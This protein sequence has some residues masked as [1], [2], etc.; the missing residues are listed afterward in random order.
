MIATCAMAVPSVTSH[1]LSS[2]RIVTTEAYAWDCDNEIGGIVV[3]DK[4]GN[5]GWQVNLESTRSDDKMMA[6]G[7]YL[8][9]NIPLEI[10]AENNQARLY[11]GRQ[12]NAVVTTQLQGDVQVE[13]IK[14]IYAM[15]EQYLT[16]MSVLDGDFLAGTISDNGSITF[17]EGFLFLIQEDV[18][19]KRGNEVLEQ[20]TT[21]SLSPVFRNYSLHVPN[22]MHHFKKLYY[23]GQTSF[24][25]FPV[26]EGYG[27]GGIVPRPPIM[28]GGNSENPSY[29]I[30]V[31]ILDSI[32]LQMTAVTIVASKLNKNSSLNGFLTTL[33]AGG[34]V[35][36]PPVMSGGNSENSSYTKT[37]HHDPSDFS[38]FAMKSVTEIRNHGITD[39]INGHGGLVPR[40]PVMSGGNSEN[41]SYTKTHHHDPSDFSVADIKSM[42][43]G[44][45]NII[46]GGGGIIPNR[47]VMSGGNSENPCYTKL[48]QDRDYDVPR[49]NSGIN[50]TGEVSSNSPHNLVSNNQIGSQN[51]TTSS[52]M[53]ECAVE[54]PVYI[55]QL[56]GILKVYNLYGTSCCENFMTIDSNGTMF[57]PGQ[58]IGHD[59]EDNV[60][61]INCSLNADTCDYLN[62]GI[63]G[64][65]T[66]DNITWGS[67]VPC[68][69]DEVYQYLY[70][71]NSLTLVNGCQFN[72]PQGS[73]VKVLGDVSNDCKVDIADVTEM[74]DLMLATGDMSSFDQSKTA[75]DVNE[76]G[77]LNIADVTTLIDT[78]LSNA[79]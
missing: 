11:M 9:N 63:L 2:T 53:V 77:K 67:I 19:Y 57:F 54:V 45:N 6:N 69:G 59:F 22:G 58:I 32:D 1:D 28:S 62:L 41:S 50:V 75:A 46:R 25:G 42:T 66:S 65:A 31:H 38:N 20:N 40:P 33:G 29:K 49:A 8:Q 13:T 48:Y 64:L 7:F 16:N 21:F 23:I 55:E 47:P 24:W 35:P 18:T 52:G 17:N 79:D 3:S 76:D 27:G 78:L 15:P 56:N 72:V 71:D 73:H 30:P 39:I 51:A 36:R 5:M 14:S 37:H 34:L 26:R 44:R 70:A 68:N 4:I 10:D 43:A 60:D 61:I 12:L 74:V